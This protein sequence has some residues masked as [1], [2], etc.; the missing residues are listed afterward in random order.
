MSLDV[1]R[2]RVVA[3]VGS[4]KGCATPTTSDATTVGGAPGEDLTY[5]NCPAGS[6]LYHVWTITV[7]NGLAFQF[8]WFDNQDRQAADESLRKH[9]IET[10]SFDR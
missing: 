5:P 6:G 9:E 1:W 10:V 2:A 3:L 4:F 7:H 8:V